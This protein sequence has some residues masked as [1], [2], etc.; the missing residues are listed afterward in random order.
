MTEQIG[1][2]TGVE[3][4]QGKP[5]FSPVLLT[6]A[7]YLGTLAAA[8]CLGSLGAPV[9]V[10]DA[11]TLVPGKWSR[12]VSRRETP[13]ASHS[14][15]QFLR[16]LLDFGARYE[17]HVL[18]PTS[19]DMAW[20]IA[21][22]RDSL[23][24]NYRL[25]SPSLDCI[26]TLLDKEC[27]YQVA[28]HAGLA[29]PDTYYPKDDGSL[30]AAAERVQYPALI[31][32]LTQVT[33]QWGNKGAVVHSAQELL[34]TYDQLRGLGS[35]SD[36]DPA[37]GLLAWP[38]I[39]RYYPHA[40]QDIYELSGFVDE[41]GQ[42]FDF[43]ASRKI[44]Q[45]PA[46]LGVG[47]CFEA[48]PVQPDLCAGIIRMC[49]AVKYYGVFNAELIYT[50]E[51]GY[52]L[53]AFNPRYYNEMRFEINRGMPLPEFMYFAALG[54]FDEM[55]EAIL[56]SKQHLGLNDDHV[57]IHSFRFFL[58]LLAKGLTGK[59]HIREVRK[60]VHW[61]QDHN[62]KRYDLVG[63]RGDPLPGLVDVI[64]GLKTYGRNPKHFIRSM[65]L[66]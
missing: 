43:R 6:F 45:Y 37:S 7:G 14:M 28:T 58:M 20:L 44:L 23:A 66:R 57:V 11:Q 51:S 60:W 2:V 18:Y 24:A 56:R 59:W 36:E 63:W 38:M 19:D 16:W 29:A 31:K 50:R 9:T 30:R 61:Y 41:S 55:R 17:G 42:H 52:M 65:V 3:S 5:L 48:A 39:Q 64:D 54:R 62:R 32:P 33:V 13:P 26:R 10:A 4:I 47:I 53:I 8:R 46:S 35:L 15:E 27:L 34:D 25:Y 21:Q 12:Y 40:T 49:R 1:L 22:Y